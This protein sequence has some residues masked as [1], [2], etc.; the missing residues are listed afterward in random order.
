MKIQGKGKCIFSYLKLVEIDSRLI[1]LR[2]AVKAQI[3]VYRHRYDR[4][5]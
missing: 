4:K 2:K 3:Y 1:A 5:V